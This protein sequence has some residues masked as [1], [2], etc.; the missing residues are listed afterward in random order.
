MCHCTLL[1]CLSAPVILFKFSNIS[2]FFICSSI[3]IRSGL[4]LVCVAFPSLIAFVTSLLTIS[5][6]HLLNAS[7]LMESGS[8]LSGDPKTII[9]FLLFCI[10]VSSI[11]LAF[12]EFWITLSTFVFLPVTV[13]HFCLLCHN[14]TVF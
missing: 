9:F 8:G 14:P 2:H 5:V 11:S 7:S 13:D 1:N 4:L 12:S 3:A 10:P 6:L